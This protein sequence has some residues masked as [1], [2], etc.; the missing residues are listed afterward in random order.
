MGNQETYRVSYGGASLWITMTATE[1]R[2]NRAGGGRVGIQGGGGEDT[3]TLEV[4][5][6]T[7][8]AARADATAV[9]AASC[10]LKLTLPSLPQA[11]NVGPLDGKELIRKLL[12]EVQT[13]AVRGSQDQ[14]DLYQSAMSGQGGK[15]TWEIVSQIQKRKPS[16]V[17]A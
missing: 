15:V 13:S 9:D 6:V 10:W 11:W 8:A 12:I 5:A 4:R 16:T 1:F 2:K 7:R 3:I 14:V 17:I